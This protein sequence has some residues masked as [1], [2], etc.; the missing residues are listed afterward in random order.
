MRLL[1][2]LQRSAE[3]GNTK[4]CQYGGETSREMQHLDGPPSRGTNGTASLYP[5]WVRFKKAFYI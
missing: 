3:N 1:P 4:S 2:G 5:F